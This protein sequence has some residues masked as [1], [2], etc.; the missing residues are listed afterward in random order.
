MKNI[1]L[2]VPGVFIGGILLI[3]LLSPRS[4]SQPQRQVIEINGEE[5]TDLIR[6][7]LRPELEQGQQYAASQMLDAQARRT[8][9]YLKEV[10][11]RLNASQN[12]LMCTRAQSLYREAIA[13]QD[14]RGIPLERTYR[15][16]LRT[17][18]NFAK[19]EATRVEVYSG[20]AGAFDTARAYVFDAKILADLIVAAREGVTPKTCSF[21]PSDVV[22]F[23][24]A[25][26][27]QAA[28]NNGRNQQT[29]S[30]SG[31]AQ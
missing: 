18:T 20:Q 31:A 9:E 6:Q 28:L 26:L 25:Y 14:E 10:V 15:D 23:V 1:K 4:Q 8:E 22:P 11:M 27:D 29:Q 12:L 30:V 16:K 5:A 24:D 3:G 19:E 21:R 2:I 13:A 17:I 7:Q